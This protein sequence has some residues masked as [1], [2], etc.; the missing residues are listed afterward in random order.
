MLD[1]FLRAT[2]ETELKAALP[3]F[4]NADGD[5][6]TA[7]H[8]WALDPIGTLVT[9]PAEVDAVGAVTTPATVDGR[10]HV[11]L[12]LLD[13]SL[14]SSVPSGLVIDPAPLT[15]SRVWA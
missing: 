15:P 6:I 5:W 7:S 12:R 10:F 3:G 14:L 8:Q 2:S 9:A 1:L 11:N 13:D 4:V